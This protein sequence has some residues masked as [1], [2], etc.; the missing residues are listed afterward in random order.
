MR[1]AGR[2]KTG[3]I[4]RAMRVMR[5]EMPAMTTVVRATATTLLTMPERVS[6]K[7]RW[8]PMTSLLRRLTRA[9]VWVRVKKATGMRWTWS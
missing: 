7:A 2:T 8:A 4:T 1:R 9:P 5:Q 3:S 6:L